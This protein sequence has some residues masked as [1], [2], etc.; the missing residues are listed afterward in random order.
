MRAILS[1]G[2]IVVPM[3]LVSNWHLPIDG[4]VRNCVI[5][6]CLLKLATISSDYLGHETEVA[7]VSLRASLSGMHVLAS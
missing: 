6:I 2:T 5:I 1:G 3:P 7:G 4:Q